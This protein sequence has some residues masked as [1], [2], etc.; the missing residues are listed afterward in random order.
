[1]L[2]PSLTVREH[3]ELFASFRPLRGAVA[4]NST[5]AAD[6]STCAAAYKDVVRLEIEKKLV[7]VGL[8]DDAERPAGT[9]SGGQR[10]KL[11]LAIA[12]I[13]DPDVVLLDEPTA[14]MDP[15]SRRHAWDVMRGLAG[16]SDVAT[17]GDDTT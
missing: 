9:L 17:P 15:L 14:G 10:R 6:S 4:A 2:W 13:G 7:A 12:F 8:M 1:M 3:L 16:R 5:S 11:S